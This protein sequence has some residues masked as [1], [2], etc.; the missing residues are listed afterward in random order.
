ML[1]F[2]TRTLQYKRI[3]V[4]TQ[5]IERE[6]TKFENNR[7]GFMENNGKRYNSYSPNLFAD[8]GPQSHKLSK[9]KVGLPGDATNQAAKP[10]GFRQ[11]Y[12][13]MFSLCKS[14]LNM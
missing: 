9:I 10:I 1:L 2:T 4:N 11:V 12:C 14:M 6:P 8:T 3:K 7:F 5:I 13:F